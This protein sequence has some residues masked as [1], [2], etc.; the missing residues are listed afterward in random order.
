M[1][2]GVGVKGNIAVDNNACSLIH[3]NPDPTLTDISS[4]LDPFGCYPV[5][6]PLFSFKV[7]HLSAVY[8]V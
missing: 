7:F 2:P 1:I 3:D 4:V 6:R 5:K 8:L